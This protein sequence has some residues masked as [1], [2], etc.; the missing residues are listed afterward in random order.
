MCSYAGEARRQSI[1]VRKQESDVKGNVMTPSRLFHAPLVASGA[2]LL[3]AALVT[4][5]LYWRTALTQWENFSIWLITGGLLLAAVAALALLLDLALRRAGRMH[6]PDFAL[7]TV[8]VLLSVL[9]AFVHSRDGYTAVL[10]EGLALSAIVAVLLLAAG[11]R[12]WTLCAARL[13]SGGTQA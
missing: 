4:D 13:R 11:W 2:T 1:D 8:A 7:L 12:G 6:W 5:V 10:P 3:M 9:N